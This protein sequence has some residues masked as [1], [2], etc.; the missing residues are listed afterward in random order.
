MPI[1]FADVTVG[2][3]TRLQNQDLKELNKPEVLG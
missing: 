3:S 1:K 2:I